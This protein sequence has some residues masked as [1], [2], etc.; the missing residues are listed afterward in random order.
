[1]LPFVLPLAIAIVSSAPAH[2]D[3]EVPGELDR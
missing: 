1:M 2:N 3:Q